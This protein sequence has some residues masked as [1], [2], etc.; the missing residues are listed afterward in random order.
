MASKR[1]APTVEQI[2][3]LERMLKELKDGRTIAETKDALRLGGILSSMSAWVDWATVLRLDRE[4][5]IAKRLHEAV[6]DFNSA[7]MSLSSVSLL[8]QRV[9]QA[10]RA[11]EEGVA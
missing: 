11:I 7:G 4:D 2:E 9:N 10:A 8:L 5:S 1:E 3:F 6:D